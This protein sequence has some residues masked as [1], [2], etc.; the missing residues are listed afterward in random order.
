MLNKQIAAEIGLSEVTVK[1]YRRHLREKMGAT[2]VADLVR[3]AAKL[4]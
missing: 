4:S 3:M 2:S 1:V